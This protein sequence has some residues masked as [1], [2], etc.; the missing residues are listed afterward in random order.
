MSLSHEIMGGGGRGLI[1]T[2]SA[3]FLLGGT[4]VKAF[5]KIEEGQMG[6]RTHFGKATR[7]SGDKE[8]ELYGIVGPGIRVV[9]P[10]THAIK[11]ISIQDRTNTLPE[12]QINSEGE[13]LRIESYIRWA[14]RKDGDNPYK[15]LFKV[16]DSTELTQTVSTMLY[17]RTS[18][19]YGRHE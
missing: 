14:V 19:G 6:V 18:Q 2:V 4:A 16:E 8:G 12:I 17:G 9:V 11:N 15:A 7:T 3:S 1:T 13:Q 5:T 10:F